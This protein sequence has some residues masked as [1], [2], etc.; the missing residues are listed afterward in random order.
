MFRWAYK[1]IAKGIMDQIDYPAII[2]GFKDNVDLTVILND[3]E[4]QK[5]ILDFTDALFERY[6]LKVLGGIGGSLK[7]T[8]DVPNEGGML[9]ALPIPAKYKKLLNNPFIQMIIGGIG[10][11]QPQSESHLP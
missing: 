11:N 10:K 2:K 4:T 7:G 5:T 9:S 1:R 6:K 3:E 8:V